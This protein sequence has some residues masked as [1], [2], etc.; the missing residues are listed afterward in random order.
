MV[1]P[2]DR[3]R[4]APKT[5]AKPK[6]AAKNSAPRLAKGLAA[7]DRIAVHPRRARNLPETV[8]TPLL[9]DCAMLKPE[10]VA[11][12]LEYTNPFTSV[13]EIAAA[14]PPP[15]LL[16][17]GVKEKRFADN[18]RWAEAHMANLSVVEIDAGHGVNMEGAE[19]FN[20]HV[21]AFVKSH[22]DP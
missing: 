21:S 9:E 3:G 22:A 4:A 12:T 5:G 6:A 19:A 13:R 17:C 7:I 11:N 14:N 20:M 16:C 10:G 18:R 2:Q 8:K 15:L 1:T